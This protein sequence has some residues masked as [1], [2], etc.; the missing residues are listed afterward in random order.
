MADRLTP[1]AREIVTAA[2]DLLEESG[3]AHLTMRT[4]ADRL[5]IKAPSLY[6]HFPDKQAVEVELVALLLTETAETL[7]AAEARAPGSLEALAGAYRD[8]ALAHPHLY[9]LATE[10]PLPRA[11]LPAGLEDRAALPL[12]RTCAD[13]M[14]LARAVWAFAHGMVILEIHGRFPADADLDAAWK[15]GLAALHA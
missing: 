7:E 10:R 2:R 11:A 12:L 5:G 6:K 13:D 9:R 15:R 8:H 14:D 3:A 4:L 1:R